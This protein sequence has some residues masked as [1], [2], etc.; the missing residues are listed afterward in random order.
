MAEP[1]VRWLAFYAENV[2]PIF[3]E[4]VSHVEKIIIGTL[5][6]SAGAHV[7]SNEPA[8][9]LFGYL[10]HSLVGRGVMLIGIIILLLNFIDGLYRLAKVNWHVAWQ[11]VM[12]VFYIALSVRMIQLIL[13]FRGE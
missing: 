5:I 4:I 2:E 1:R 7:S 6:I 8:I 9:Q 3:K 13:A 10:R 11:I 12:S